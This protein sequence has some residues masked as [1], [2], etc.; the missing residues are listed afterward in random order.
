MGGP[1]RSPHAVAG[2]APWWAVPAQM[3]PNLNS[4]E[5]ANSYQAMRALLR[6][7][8][9]MH[10]P[11]TADWTAAVTGSGSTSRV[12]VTETFLAL[13]ATT[14]SQALIRTQVY[15]L[16]SNSANNQRYIDWRKRLLLSYCLGVEQAGAGP[17]TSFMQLKEASAHGALAER[18]IGIQVFQDGTNAR[19]LSCVSYG[20]AGATTSAAVTLPIYGAVKIDILHD[21][22]GGTIAWY[23][24]NVLKVTHSIA[25]NIPNAAGT[26]N[27]YLVCSIDRPSGGDVANRYMSLG[28]VFLLMEM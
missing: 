20:T 15:G 2:F 17:I 10:F 5:F 7:H 25:A 8:R 1:S 26:A 22:V 13:G 19:Q 6:D 28:H 21:P 23:V 14:I 27:A 4:K 18:G 9:F 12:S 11:M 16:F 24:D 3:N